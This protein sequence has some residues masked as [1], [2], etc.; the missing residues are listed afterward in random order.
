MSTNNKEN[1]KCLSDMS[2][3]IMIARESTAKP[4][5]AV[6]SAELPMRNGQNYVPLGENR[7]VIFARNGGNVGSVSATITG[8]GSLTGRNVSRFNYGG[9]SGRTASEAFEEVK[10]D[11]LRN[12]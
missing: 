12:I 8:D 10:R 5:N 3:E 6:R 9:S 11:V 4:L 7:G 1:I 2:K